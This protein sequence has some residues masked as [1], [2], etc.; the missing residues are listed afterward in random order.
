VLNFRTD[1]LSRSLHSHSQSKSLFLLRPQAPWSKHRAHYDPAPRPSPIM[2]THLERAIEQI[3]DS[4]NSHREVDFTQHTLEDGNV[5][6]TQ[7]RV[8]KDVCLAQIPG[9]FSLLT[10]VY[11]STSTTGPGARY[12]KTDT[13]TV[14]R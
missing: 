7:E 13:R 12:V 11:R 3:Q 5:V 1:H 8:V 14:F 10:P 9:I 4:R 2:S 6:S